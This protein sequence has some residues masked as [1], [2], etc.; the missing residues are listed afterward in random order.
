MV[1]TVWVLLLSVAGLQDAPRPNPA[2][3]ARAV[4]SEVL[5]AVEAVP[6]AERNA[7]LARVT[8]ELHDRILA[9]HDDD[10]S[11]R[12]RRENLLLGLGAFFDHGDL[13]A[14]TPI[15]RARL[16]GVVRDDER[17]RRQRALK[18]MTLSGRHDAAKH[19][20]L[21]AALTTVVGPFLAE[22]IGRDKEI[23][24]A[25][26][27]QSEQPSGQ[28]FSFIDLAYDLAGIRYAAWILGDGEPARLARKPPPVTRLVADFG[29]LELPEG[30][31]W[32]TFRER[33]N[34]AKRDAYDAIVGKIHGALDGALKA[35]KPSKP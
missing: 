8:A 22:R 11:T 6:A 17:E 23:A 34:G 3:S 16:V 20:Y 28:G 30:L 9:A 29:E 12:R 27:L 19:F 21:S 10:M 13:L 32:D 24:D 31:D 18:S 25:R 2:S 1:T 15:V 26:R 33:Y 5:F 7:A 4:F 35:E 14:R